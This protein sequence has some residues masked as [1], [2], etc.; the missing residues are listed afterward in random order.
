M[1]P[2]A[3]DRTILVSQYQPFISAFAAIPPLSKAS[4]EW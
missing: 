2:I 1:L 3:P 4:S